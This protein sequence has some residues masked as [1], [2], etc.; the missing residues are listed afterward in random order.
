[1]KTL[2]RAPY[3]LARRVLVAC[4]V[5]YFF[6]SICELAARVSNPLRY[7]RDRNDADLLSSETLSRIRSTVDMGCAKATTT[8]QSL[9]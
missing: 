6:G 7:L 5:I 4:C 3:V 9:L 8:V 1:M 2:L